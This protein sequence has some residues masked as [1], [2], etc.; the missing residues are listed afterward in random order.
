MA[1]ER[2][3][4]FTGQPA[5]GGA[6]WHHGALDA[7]TERL[8][9]LEVLHV[10]GIVDLGD[11]RLNGVPLFTGAADAAASGTSQ[12]V[13]RIPYLAA[14]ADRLARG[15]GRP[16]RSSIAATGRKTCGRHRAQMPPA[17]NTGPETARLSALRNM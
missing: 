12:G 14:G 1:D 11:W 8:R 2:L 15:A 3:T 9:L 6:N 7:T 5:I 4:G 13:R 10:N 17:C 16:A